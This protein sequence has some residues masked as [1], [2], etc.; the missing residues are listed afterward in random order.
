MNIKLFLSQ[1]GSI[2]IGNFEFTSM[3]GLEV[4]G[5]VDDRVIVDVDAWYGEI[6]FRVGWFSSME[7]AFR[8]QHQ[9]Q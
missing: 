3:R 2:D 7:I 5:D 1:I 9:T 6:G 8:S 4:L